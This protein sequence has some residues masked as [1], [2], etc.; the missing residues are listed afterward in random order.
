[1]PGHE[2]E[3]WLGA[4][5]FARVVAATRSRDRIPV[6]LKLSRPD[7]AGAAAQLAREAQALAAIGVPAVPRLYEAGTL[8]DG[9]TYLS[10]ERLAG[11]TLAHR[12]AEVPGALPWEEERR[13]ALELL[14]ALARI[15][16]AGWAHG[17]LKPENIVLS[18]GGVRLLDLGNAEAT[19]GDGPRRSDAVV[20]TVEYLAPERCQGAAADV[21]SDVYAAGC[22]LFE[23][24]TGHPPFFGAEGDVRQAQVSRRPP[25]TPVG[26][27]RPEAEEVL[28]RSLAKDPEARPAD[29][30]HFRRA[31]AAALEASPVLGLVR[32]SP[33]VAPVPADPPLAAERRTAG[34]VLLDGVRDVMRVR[35]SAG[36]VG[37]V[38]VHSA[39]GRC[40]LVFDPV[41]TGQ[42]ARVA[43]RGA[44][45]LLLT[46]LAQ[47]GLVDVD[48]VLVQ[49]RRGG[50]LRYLNPALARAESYPAG[51]DPLGLLVTARAAALLED[52]ALL[53]VT[54]RPDRF[55]TASDVKADEHTAL[56]RG[57]APFVGRESLLGPLVRAA[58]KACG[59]KHPVVA[60]V[61]AE[62][63]LGKSAL[64]HRL[65]ERL[66]R[67][68]SAPRVL[69]LRAPGRGGGDPH[70]TL[71]LLLRASIDLPASGSG[72]TSEVLAALEQALPDSGSGWL[73]VAMVLG[74]VDASEPRVRALA[75]A[76]GALRAALVRGC[77]QALRQLA[78]QRPLCLVLDDAHDADDAAL[79]ALEFAAL[80]EA[81]CPLFVCA[82]GRPSL[83]D[84]RP[85]FGE[86]AA[87]AVR[88]RV[89]PLSPSESADLCRA[90]L[91]P[92][93]HVPSRAIDRL[94]ERSS[95]SPLLLVEL[96]RGLK[97]EGLVST[98]AGGRGAHVT[99]GLL[100]S[101][102]S[103]PSVEWL[104]VRELADMPPELAMHARLVALL[105]DEFSIEEVSGVLEALERTGESAHFPL[106]AGAATRGLLAAGLLVRHRGGGI[107]FRH[108]LVRDAVAHGVSRAQRLAIHRAALR[109]CRNASLPGE[110]RLAFLARHAEPAGERVAAA[111]AALELARRAAS[112]QAYVEAEHLF[113]RA[114][115]GLDGGGHA[116]L[117]ALR[118]RGVMRTRLG[119]HLEAV[120]DLEDAR[121]EARRLDDRPVE[122]EC[123]LDLATSLDWS[124]E[125]QAS[126]ARVADAADVAGPEAEG[127]LAARLLLGRGRSRW[128]DARWAE[129]CTLLEE[130]ERVAARAEEPGY[131]SR[132]IA[133]VILG[134][135]LPPL[136]RLEEAA[137]ALARAE[138]LAREHGDVLHLSAAL[139]N[140][141]NLR[142]ACRDLEGALADQR[143][144]V[145][146]GRE[147]GLSGVEYFAEYNTGELLY[148]AGRGSEAFRHVERAAA[149]EQSHPEVAPV[150]MALLL[151]ARVLLHQGDVVAA[152]A[153]LGE[154][155]TALS[156]AGSAPGPSESVLADMV[157]LATRTASTEEWEALLDRS[158]RDSVEQEPLEVCEQRVLAAARAGRAGEA[159]EAAGATLVLAS[160]L[161]G[162]MDGRLQV[163]LARSLGRG[164]H[165]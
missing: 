96:V 119:R 66:R 129:A 145:R 104:A 91:L 105:G 95:G 22:V 82:L 8:P 120:Q 156:A 48:T 30:A 134:A 12:L 67:L 53:P 40:A 114:L 81:R 6:A 44:E 115:A 26:R 55:R 117:A 164:D 136:G 73:A 61:I 76:P 150:P 33:P 78:R 10:L 79:D 124:G 93:E 37:G 69:T 74:H 45:N 13:I 1:M 83:A 54:G 147:L 90:L 161:P 160:R 38:V 14:D 80:A 63:G 87:R 133:C 152:R 28:R 64:A 24:F 19:G 85:R 18:E 92:A 50:A 135:A 86:R 138:R 89:D 71:A 39:G 49:R 57:S 110:R 7:V 130:A 131:E 75:D 149:L 65:A 159:R 140:R 32:E 103:L 100:E 108:L 153:R 143:E 9:T 77:G 94:V 42:P 122:A 70:A 158:R 102:P 163:S 43:L 72:D 123:L 16:A 146:L 36:R 107:G 139:N 126:A 2:V 88:S 11:P 137:E 141:R 41:D 59:S 62:G 144:V 125:F 34:L 154:F 51:V 127:L 47:R 148:Q 84:A 98:D 60:S 21:R 157:E 101:A 4:G 121:R 113:G 58:E 29:A 111:D 165:A 132:V 151:W 99:T 25:R 128:R 23:V 116:R 20:G 5:G 56:Q 68:P 109:Y 142:V 15:H 52:E 97:R 35:Q 106:D 118:G 3:G 27:L 162:L 31:L 46:G 155:R 112:R 17:D